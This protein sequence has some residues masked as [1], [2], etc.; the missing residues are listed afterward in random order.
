MKLRII[1]TLFIFSFGCFVF[2]SNS[3]GRATGQS[4]G[5]TGAPNDNANMNRTC[6]A[7]HNSG[8]FSVSPQL[9]I[10]DGN[11]NI[12]TG[13]LNGGETYS[14][15]LTVNETAGT[16][17]GYGFQMVALNAAQGV[18]GAAVNTWSVPASTNNV[19]LATL[20]N[21]RQYAE[22]NTTSTSNEF[23]I[24]W[25]A[26]ASG[27]VTFYYIG[28]AI[29]GNS[30]ASG[31]NANPGSASFSTITSTNELERKVALDIFPNPVQE[32]INIKTSSQ[33]SDTYDLNL[34]DINGRQIFTEKIN[35]P[36]GENLVPIDVPTLSSGIYNL[37]LSDGKN[38]ITKK[39]VKM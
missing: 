30:M 36:A 32:V 27:D 12:V 25:T 19:Q 33:V 24:D 14:I 13:S 6:Q 22:Q 2:L 38:L 20:G 5:N 29:N 4:E 35:I 8:S 21:G 10:Q 39:V 11:G 1:Y 18:D 34:F 28:N 37:I 9:E 26:P 15:K 7:C 23:T 17:A 3:G 31:D 16:P